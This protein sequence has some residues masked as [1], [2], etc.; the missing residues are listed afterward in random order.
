M[1]RLVYVFF[2]AV[3]PWFSISCEKESFKVDDGGVKLEFSTDTLTFDTVFTTVGTTTRIVTIYNRSSDNLKLSTV[4]LSGGVASHFRMNVDGDTSLVARDIEIEA[5]DSIFIFVQAN[6][7][8]TDAT[9]PFVVEDAIVFSNGQRVVLTAWGRNAI[10][11]RILPSDSTWFTVIDCENW[12]HTLPHVFIDPAAVLDGHTLTLRNGDELYFYDDAM[13]IIDS[14]AHLRVQGTEDAPVLFTSMRHD[15]WYDYLPGQWQTIWFYNYST[16]NVIDHAV[17]ENGTCGLR[18]YPGSQLTVSNTVIRNMS[19]CGIVGQAATITGRNLLVYDCLADVT[20]LRGG[21]YDFRNCTFANYWSYTAR[22][23]EC[24]V[25]SN[26]EI[27][28]GEV[29]GG[30]LLKADFRDCIIWG[31]Y[32]KEFLLSELEGF[33]MNY[34]LNLHSIVKGGEWSEDPLFTDPR[35]D[36]YTLQEE[37]PAIGIGYQFEN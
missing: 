5:G 15:G 26:N 31:T 19:D 8:P 32:Q 10:Y 24:I 13:L 3:I 33:T 30:D 20:V 7:N 35:E 29:L 14:N 6:I 9:M 37:S 34:N 27:R 28:G 23:I 22:Q 25:L 2:L 18:C 11:H 17:I 12:N 4:T 16:G 36:D 21:S 1:R